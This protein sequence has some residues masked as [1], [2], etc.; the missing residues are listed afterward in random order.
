MLA[1]ALWFYTT[2]PKPG[3]SKTFN[4]ISQILPKARSDFN[5]NDSRIILED[6]P[7]TIK[8]AESEVNLKT[9][10]IPQTA[11][12]TVGIPK[13]A[14]ISIDDLRSIRFEIDIQNQNQGTVELNSRNLS[15][16]EYLRLVNISP[17]KV[18]VRFEPR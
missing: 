7:I 18:Q 10:V 17:K 15:I 13:E 4:T 14:N 3:T 6:V 8:A 11:S 9:T 1:A 12:I 5:F 2:K 16:P